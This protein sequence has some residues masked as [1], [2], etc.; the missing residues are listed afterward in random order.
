MAKYHNNNY[1]GRN[2]NRTRMEH[3]INEYIKAEELRVVMKN[4]NLGV[5][6]KNKALKLAKE[7]SM[8]L[9]LIAEKAN[10]PVAKIT[11]YT[12]YKYQEQQKAQKSKAK[13][14]KQDLKEFR[15]TV[16]T[17]ENDVTMKVN[18]ARNFLKGNDKVRFNLRFRGRENAHK[19]L[20]YNKLNN[21]V[22]SLEDIAKIE[23][24]IKSQGSE[25]SVT[26]MPK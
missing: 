16:N 7:N 4:E 15:I 9:I 22:A 11:E 13:S 18:R 26:L 5:M 6:T 12:K 21:V 2:R 14:K 17:G 10:P 19:E 1:R 8:D 3:I 20:G 23:G 25:I 24:E